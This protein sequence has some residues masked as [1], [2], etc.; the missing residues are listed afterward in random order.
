MISQVH[1]PKVWVDKPTA[2]VAAEL[3]EA[4]EEQNRARR[5][6][7]QRSGVLQVG[8]E[9]CGQTTDF[10]ASLGGTTQE[11]SHCRAFVDVGDLPW[12]EDFG[13]PEE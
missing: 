11:C 6:P 1:R 12:D 4:Y 3:I 2:A 5:L 8:C 9:E 13:V 10:P 7:D